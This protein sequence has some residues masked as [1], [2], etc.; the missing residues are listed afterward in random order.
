MNPDGVRY[1]VPLSPYAVSLTAYDGVRTAY[2][3][4]CADGVPAYDRP[5]RGS[6]AVRRRLI[7]ESR[8]QP[9][10]PQKEKKKN[11]EKT[12]TDARKGVW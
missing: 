11:P 9:E 6:Y 2:R 12:L 8:V 10:T 4:A 3:T 7:G 5:R 1:G